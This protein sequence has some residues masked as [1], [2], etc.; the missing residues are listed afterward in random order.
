MQ[1]D[2]IKITLETEKI[3]TCKTTQQIDDAV[4]VEKM[5]SQEQPI[6][7][8]FANEH[9]EELVKHVDIVAD[10][11]TKES[12]K[13]LTRYLAP[14]KKLEKIPLLRTNFSSDGKVF[15]AIKTFIKNIEIR[16][17]IN[18]FILGVEEN[19]FDEIWKNTE[20]E[21][22]KEFP[23]FIARPTCTIT[24]ASSSAG[25]D[26]T[27]LRILRYL[28]DL[29][30]KSPDLEKEY[31]GDSEL[32]RLT[33]VLILAAANTKAPVLILGDTGTGKEVVARAIHNHGAR[34]DDEFTAVNCGAISKE[35]LE[36]ELFGGEKNITHAGQPLKKGLWESTGKGTLFLD[37]IGDLSPDHQVKILRALE[38][39]S[40]RRVGGIEDIKVK[41]RIVA[42]TNRN[43]FAMVQAKDFR[44]DLYYRLRGSFI[45]TPTLKDHLVDVSNLSL[46][47][48]RRITKNARATLSSA[49]IEEL[50]RYAWPG[51][52]RE[53]KMVLTNLYSLFKREDPSVTN[54]KDIFYLEGRVFLSAEGLPASKDDNSLER[55]R[56]LQHLKR[57][58]EV[59]HLCH[60]K[61]K[62]SLA[63]DV[64]NGEPLSSIRETL[65]F[66]NHEIELLCNKPT[67]FHDKEIFSAVYDFKGKISY[68][69]SLLSQDRKSAIDFLEVDVVNVLDTLLLMISSEIE[70]V[71]NIKL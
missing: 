39:N 24:G 21:E 34:K 32:A 26:S 62:G 69:L 50:C 48:W 45:R 61:F 42:A 5:K 70:K 22:E 23:V 12:R 66:L 41:A 65:L 19:I 43:L 33:R 11:K 28:E 1:V 17:I 6:V 3:V 25:L 49:V 2:C 68:L 20:K 16:G 29:Y 59:I 13:E 44:E 56:C 40:I 53:L 67:L 38:N 27:E 57:A 64:K 51:N 46:F 63:E 9:L 54:L 14:K 7:F 52:V 36:Y 30:G 60:Y 71:M 4:A 18:T 31:I 8:L 58:H 55:A 15:G 47:F 10:R 37:E 35:L